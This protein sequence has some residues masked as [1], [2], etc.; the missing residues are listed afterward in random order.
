MEELPGDGLRRQHKL[1]TKIVPRCPVCGV[2]DFYITGES[3]STFSCTSTFID[4]CVQ[5]DEEHTSEAYQQLTLGK[6]SANLYRDADSEKNEDDELDLISYV[7]CAVCGYTALFE[8]LGLVPWQELTKISDEYYIYNKL[9]GPQ[10]VIMFCL[11]AEEA[12]RYE[13]LKKLYTATDINILPE[14]LVDKELAPIAKRIL[15]DLTKEEKR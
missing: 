12:E 8:E 9:E 2:A 14:Y 7:E 1:V 15:N 10:T 13:R 6:E 11:K 5:V 3:I 4:E